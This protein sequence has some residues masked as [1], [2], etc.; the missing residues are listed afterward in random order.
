MNIIKKITITKFR[1]IGEKET[2]EPAD[3]NVISG[4]N[5]SGKS[6]YLK[7][8][9]L[10]FNGETDFRKR[11]S[12]HD[13]FNKWFRDNGEGGTRDIEIEI[14]FSKGNYNDPQCIN[15]GFS[16]KKTF[17]NDGG[18]RTEF[19]QKDGTKIEDT[20][21]LSYKRANAII[22]ENIKFIYI[23]AIRDYTFQTEIRGQLL[24]IVNSADGRS[25]AG[26][27]LEDAFDRVKIA[28]GGEETI[29]DGKHSKTKGELEQL[30]RDVSENLKVQIRPEVNFSTLLASLDF[31][32]TG[33]IETKPR[34]SQK[35]KDQPVKL[36]HRGDGIQMHFLSV[37]LSFIA[38]R[39]KKH[40]Y[41]WGYEEP[42]I[43]LELKRQ[44]E[45]ADL[46]AKNFCKKV[47]IFITTHSPAFIFHEGQE[48]KKRVY[49]V[50]FE[51]DG[52]KKRRISKISKID[53]YYEDLLGRCNS[54]NS[55]QEKEALEREIWGVTQGKISAALGS[56]LD[57][58]KDHRHIS[59]SELEVYK[60]K[61]LEAKEEISSL[62]KHNSS[63][64]KEAETAKKELGESR[65]PKIFI[66]E[67]KDMLTT[68]TNLFEKAKIEGVKVFTSKGKDKDHW[69]NALMTQTDLHKDYCPTIFRQYDR[70]GLTE[71]QV[72]KLEPLISKKFAKLQN[73][74]AKFLPVCEVENFL[75]LKKQEEG[76]SFDRN[77]K[78]IEEIEDDLRGKVKGVMELGSKFTKGEVDAFKIFNS[79]DQK[80]IN[81]ARK[82]KQHFFPGKLILTF[83]N[84]RLTANN[85][86]DFEYDKFPQL[87]KDYL[88][89]IKSFFDKE[90]NHQKS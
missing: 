90:T 9:N 20:R 55:Q 41:I 85:I 6:N 62:Q 54:Q 36:R 66:C 40:S 73:Y 89:E 65:P 29:K 16:A 13:D 31:H 50:R 5:D 18:T 60:N 28:L 58:I 46:F 81:D 45:F 34:R 39:D 32:T 24:E 79:A 59:A 44:F 63:L 12:S 70:D 74:K 43:A 64:K 84:P 21:H 57:D 38:E 23:P 42:E 22:S 67:D 7:A 25:K 61:I 77:E 68:W 87:L 76:C 3:F 88:G 51:Q 33:Q 4:A 72:E 52:K 1:S 17:D 8:L 10:F 69:E 78:Q 86:C 48:D 26:K 14:E 53:E 35:P 11:Y 27:S 75:V 49:R 71:K 80:M 56:A 47:Q 19:F 37:L 2:I 30:I 82:D 83:L 15:N